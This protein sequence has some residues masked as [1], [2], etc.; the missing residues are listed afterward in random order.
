MC[1]AVNGF[2]CRNIV[3]LAI[4]PH[5]AFDPL[6][7]LQEHSAT[8]VYVSSQH[9]APRINFRGVVEKTYDRLWASQLERTTPNGL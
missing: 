2:V 9:S 8:S 5:E 4:N 7:I 1:R 6:W 3:E